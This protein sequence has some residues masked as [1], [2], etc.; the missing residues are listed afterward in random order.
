PNFV[1]ILADDLGYDDVGLNGCEDIPTPNIDSIAT[2]GARCTNA[3]VTCPFCSPSRAAIMTGRYQQRF[4]YEAQLTDD[5]TNPLL[6]IPAQEILLPQLLK[7]AGYVCGTVGKWHLG[8]APNLLPIARGFDEFFGFLTGQAEPGYYNAQVL[9][10]DTPLI[11]TD[12]LTDAFTREA[13]AFIN[14]HAAE[15]F[16]LYLPYRA[17][18]TPYDTPPD[19][20]VQRV[21]NIPDP[22]R[23]T[24]GAMVVALDDG[25]GQVLQTL[26]D[27]NIFDNTLIF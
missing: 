27:N 25:V 7:P 22:K 17:V 8:E 23:R 6:G 12:Y 3:Y 9:R 13:V 1:I 15:P 4:G 2:N 5:E 26:R 18:H 21:A 20:Y 10:G 14:N 24:Y 16:L 11:E 19:V